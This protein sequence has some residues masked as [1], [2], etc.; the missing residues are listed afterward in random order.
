L[1]SIGI[2]GGTFD[3]IHFGHLRMAEEMRVQLGLNQV[4]FLPAAQPPHRDETHTSAEHRAAMVGL[5]IAGNPAFVLDR[6]EL[7]RNG[8]SYTVDTLRSLRE[9][10]GAIIP[11]ILFIGSD[12]FFGLPAW[13]RWQELP[14]LAHIAVAFRPGTALR[15]NALPPELC[16]LWQHH[17]TECVADLHDAPSGK[18]LWQSVTA[19]DIASSRIR[20]AYTQGFSTRYLLPETVRD[21]IESHHL[22][23]RRAT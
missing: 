13:H 7:E 4:R 16:S 22:Y 3:P 20:E 12:A 15:E 8:P 6:R 2:F 1:Q 23:A 5:A 18:M 14:E 11:L 21:Y 19:L 17:Q 10:F 9:E